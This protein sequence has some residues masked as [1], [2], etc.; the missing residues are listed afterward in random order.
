ML[1]QTEGSE[2]AINVD[3]QRVG[4]REEGV[5]CWNSIINYLAFRVVWHEVSIQPP[6]SREMSLLRIHRMQELKNYKD[7]LAQ[8]PLVSR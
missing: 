1:F 3:R 8:T 2:N 7:H 5:D 6:L 4:S